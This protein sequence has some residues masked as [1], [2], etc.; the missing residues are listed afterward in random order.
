[1]VTV[2]TRATALALM[3]SC[4]PRPAVIA[5]YPAPRPERTRQP[6]PVGRSRITGTVTDFIT[7]VPMQGVLVMIAPQSRSPQLGV[8]DVTDDRGVYV[9]DGVRP[10]EYRLSLSY[11][12]VIHETTLQAHQGIETVFDYQFARGVDTPHPLPLE[13]PI[14]PL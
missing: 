8:T 4:A 6:I 1:M 11:W 14:L 7:H 5:T 10:A 2:M 3:C 12:D 13:P 9:L